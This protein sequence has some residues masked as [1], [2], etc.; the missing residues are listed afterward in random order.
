MTLF[1]A[2]YTTVYIYLSNCS[3]DSLFLPGSL[4]LLML[5]CSAKGM[6]CKHKEKNL[7]PTD[8]SELDKMNSWHGLR[9][10]K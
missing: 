5:L 1:N 4:G 6:W 8:I 7:L 9:W 2:H 10:K 3:C